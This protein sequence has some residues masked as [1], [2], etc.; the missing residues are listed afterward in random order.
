MDE[1]TH[2]QAE[3]P[4]ESDSGES[5]KRILFKP[6]RFT[7]IK[8][9]EIMVN[10]KIVSDIADSAPNPA[11]IAGCRSS[12]RALKLKYL[13][14]T[15]DSEFA[16]DYQFLWENIFF[17]CTNSRTYLTPISCLSTYMPTL[18]LL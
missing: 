10:K 9:T 1:T 2:S 4:R 16:S 3:Y 15:W 17:L 11:R 12:L 6:T 5:L 7:A 13:E 18:S 8:I 14:I